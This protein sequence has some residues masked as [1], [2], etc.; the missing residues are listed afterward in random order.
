MLRLRLDDAGTKM[1]FK[2]TGLH[3]ISILKS[4]PSSQP[5]NPMS[6]IVGTALSVLAG[7][8]LYFLLLTFGHPGF[9]YDSVSVGQA[10][11]T[12]ARLAKRTCPSE[13]CGVTGSLSY[14]GTANVEEI[15]GNWAR[16]SPYIDAGCRKGRSQ[17]IY[18]GDTQCNPANGI[19]SGKYAEWVPA[20][21]LSSKHP[22]ERP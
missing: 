13:S 22:S 16:V 7:G 5:I 11:V 9:G 6:L 18:E 3:P 12:S 15:R 8:L 21:S 10:W 1:S 2:S 4:A 17:Y 14:Q 19:E 20:E